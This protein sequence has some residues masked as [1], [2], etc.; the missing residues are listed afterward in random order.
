MNERFHAKD[1]RSQMLRFHAQTA[2]ST[3]TAQQPLNN[4][5]R[6]AIQ[7]LAAVLGGTQS[8]HTN[9]YDEALSL[10]SE[11]AA[12]LALRTQQI[13]A[14]ETGVAQTVDPLAGSYYLESLTDTLER[15]AR[16]L[17]DHVAK[18]GGAARAIETGYFQRAIGQ[19]AYEY[20]RAVERGEVVVVGV[21]QFTDDAQQVDLRAPDY[22]ALESAQRARVREARARRDAGAWREALDDL[23][24]AAEAT[25]EPLMPRIIEAVRARATVGEISDALRSVWG[26]FRPALATRS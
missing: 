11:S 15:E 10:P 25:S 9:S 13:L 19:V 5:V 2:G 16:E 24:S 26:T 14:H 6:V 22:S 17:L 3:L 1:P 20:Q 4:V 23:K 18:L 21:N 7:A 8:L 12:R